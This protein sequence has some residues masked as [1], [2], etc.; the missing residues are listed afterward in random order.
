MSAMYASIQA[1]L[2]GLGHDREDT[3][4]QNS[5]SNTSES[6]E[7]VE[8]EDDD[9]DPPLPNANNYTKIV[10]NSVAY[11]WLTVSLKRIISLSPVPGQEETSG[12]IYTQTMQGLEAS[13]KA[14][15]ARRASQRCS[16]VLGAPWD[17]RSFL[18]QQFPNSAESLGTLLARTITLTGSATDAQALPCE[19][20]LRQ[21][22]P[23]SGP[24]LLSILKHAMDTDGRGEGT[25]QTMFLASYY[26]EI[27][28]NVTH[29]ESYRT[30]LRWS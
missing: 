22:W 6:D 21:T 16:L 9:D 27:T 2:A 15:S 13:R 10:F 8:E 12:Q 7:E 3:H 29:Q 30:R 20:Y 17:P 23:A 5:T 25:S 11:R 28:A 24:N 19:V 4:H 26:S 14:V 1:W 18:R